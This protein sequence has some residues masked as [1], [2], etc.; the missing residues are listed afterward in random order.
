MKG[1]KPPPKKSRRPNKPTPAPPS[2]MHG[3]VII[4]YKKDGTT[5]GICD[6]CKWW[7]YWYPE[8]IFKSDPKVVVEIRERME[9]LLKRLDKSYRDL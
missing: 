1:Y 7:L 8:D 6:I 2:K 9:K 3:E 4:L 5:A